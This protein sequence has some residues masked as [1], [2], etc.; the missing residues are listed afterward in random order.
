MYIET[1]FG[2]S[3]WLHNLINKDLHL[4]LSVF[5]NVLKSM[6]FGEF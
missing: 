3:L 2:D 5:D 6:I 1:I 4:L